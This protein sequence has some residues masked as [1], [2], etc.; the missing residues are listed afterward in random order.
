MGE[1][2]ARP[3]RVL[4]NYQRLL[5]HGDATDVGD[6]LA[7]G[8]E[9]AWSNGLRRFRDAGVTDLAVRILPSAPTKAPAHRVVEADRGLLVVAPAPSSTEQFAPGVVVDDHLAAPTA[10]VSTQPSSTSSAVSALFTSA[11]HPLVEV[12]YAG[13]AAAG[14]AWYGGLNP[15]RGSP[16]M[17]SPGWYASCALRSIRITTDSV[18]ASLP[19]TGGV[20]SGTT[21][22]SMKTGSG[23]T[24]SVASPASSTVSMYGPGP[25]T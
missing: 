24:P 2:R 19:T 25:Q 10:E 23:G 21:N 1:P 13:R 8:D 7:A 9:N 4:P 14:L 20:S 22:R 15:R 16:R 3:R 6:I 11:G 5:D 17:V 18:T 12:G